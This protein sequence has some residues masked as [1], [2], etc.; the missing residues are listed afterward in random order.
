[1]PYTVKEVENMK[2]NKAKYYDQAYLEAE[3][4]NK[5]IQSDKYNN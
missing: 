2:V 5:M 3:R 4:W 1:M